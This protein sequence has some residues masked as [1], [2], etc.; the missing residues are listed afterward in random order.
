MLLIGTLPGHTYLR[1][2]YLC[3]PCIF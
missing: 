3:T 2:N 1:P